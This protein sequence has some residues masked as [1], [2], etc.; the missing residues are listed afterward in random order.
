MELAM[1]GKIE[2]VTVY[3]T[4]HWDTPVCHSFS[5]QI[6]VG[7]YEDLYINFMEIAESLTFSAKLTKQLI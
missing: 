6:K 2:A 4:G 7:I 3:E 5:E 1:I